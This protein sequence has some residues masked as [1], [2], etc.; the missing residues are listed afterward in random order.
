MVKMFCQINFKNTIKDGPWWWSTWAAFY[1]I[2]QSSN[3]TE[4]NSFN[5][6]NCLKMGRGWPILKTIWQMKL[7]DI[8]SLTRV[9]LLWVEGIFFKKN[10][11]FFIYF[12]PSQ[13]ILQNKNCTLSGFRTRIVGVEGELADH[14]TTTTVL[15]CF[16]AQTIFERSWPYL[17]QRISSQVLMKIDV[18]RSNEV[19]STGINQNYSKWH[20]LTAALQQMTLHQNI[21]QQMTLNRKTQHKN[22][23]QQMTLHQKKLRKICLSKWQITSNNFKSKNL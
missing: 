16:L 20:L 19:S 17:S 2:D 21:L 3:T 22:M 23:L 14:L 13:T 11:L 10:C 9:P 5:S 12:R 7:S 4:V 6:V 8:E 1:P 18:I 15:R